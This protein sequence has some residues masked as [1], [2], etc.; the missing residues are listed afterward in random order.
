MVLC[1]PQNERKKCIPID[2]ILWTVLGI[3]MLAIFC[4]SLKNAILYVT[5]RGEQ[6]F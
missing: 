5:V 3:W 2:T 4:S 6:F 1:K